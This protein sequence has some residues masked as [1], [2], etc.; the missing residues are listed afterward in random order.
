MT[1][2]NLS[3]PIFA[4]KFAQYSRYAVDC[5][6]NT[7]HKQAVPRLLGNLAS[8]RQNCQ[9]QKPVP[10]LSTTYSITGRFLLPS[11]TEEFRC[12]QKGYHVIIDWNKILPKNRI[13]SRIE[14]P[15]NIGRQVQK[16]RIKETRKITFPFSSLHVSDCF[17]L[18]NSIHD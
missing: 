3:L 11:A 9:F 10:I 6:Q 2:L 13:I 17:I 8:L 16:H 12:Q 18:C 14:E 4:C 15:L 1:T 7:T 5:L